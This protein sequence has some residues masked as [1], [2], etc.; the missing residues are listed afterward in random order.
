VAEAVAELGRRA[1]EALAA[2]N[3]LTLEGPAHLQLAGT[4]PVG[5]LMFLLPLLGRFRLRPLVDQL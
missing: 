4:Q 5:P 3:G 2:G 1:D